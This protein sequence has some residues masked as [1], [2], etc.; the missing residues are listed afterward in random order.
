[1]AQTG[2]ES[3]QK[4]AGKKRGQLALPTISLA[5]DEIA[6]SQRALQMFL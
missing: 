2:K 3:R 4:L 6:I 5:L 1:M